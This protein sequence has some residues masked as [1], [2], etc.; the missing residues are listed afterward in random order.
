MA[1]GLI[2]VLAIDPTSRGFCYAVL[3]GSERLIHWGCSRVPGLEAGRYVR[4][5]EAL[6]RRYR[7]QILVLEDPQRT[8][9]GRRARADIVMAGKCAVAWDVY[10]E[11]VTRAQVVQHF[12]ASG[13]SKHEI[14]VAISRWMPEL[15]AH[16]PPKR[17]IWLS[18]DERMNVFDA[19]SFALTA[20]WPMEWR[21][22]DR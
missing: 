11:T 12:E 17:K 15:E 18:E 21:K 19:I 10:V 8:A 3:E 5:V 2:R 14:A 4:R 22:E 20:L 16:L 13:R 7:P 6:I 9:R 1:P